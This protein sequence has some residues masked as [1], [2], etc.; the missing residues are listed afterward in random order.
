MRETPHRQ[1]EVF[2]TSGLT[3]RYWRER[4]GSSEED[5]RRMVELRRREQG[6][7][8]KANEAESV[9]V[10]TLLITTGKCVVT[11]QRI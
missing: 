10:K 3:W 1:V 2:L 11:V 4:D 7:A 9:G 5:D 6:R 8:G